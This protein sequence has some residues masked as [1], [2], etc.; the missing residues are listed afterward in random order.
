MSGNDL[1]VNYLT[2]AYSGLMESRL[3]EGSVKGIK[4]FYDY[5]NNGDKK[6]EGT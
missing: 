5:V 1:Y 2:R 4:G 6:T 3:A